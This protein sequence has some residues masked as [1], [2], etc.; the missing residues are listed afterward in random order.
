MPR[1][2]AAREIKRLTAG[3]AYWVRKILLERYGEKIL[4]EQGIIRRLRIEVHRHDDA[5][6]TIQGLPHDP[7]IRLHIVIGV[8]NTLATDPYLIPSEDA[9]RAALRAVCLLQKKLES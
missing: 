1:T 7:A 4:Y 8:L 5:D 6:T 2:G 3:A 9:V